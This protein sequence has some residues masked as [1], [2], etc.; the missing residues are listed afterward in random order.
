MSKN[1]QYKQQQAAAA[2]ETESQVAEAQAAETEVATEAVTETPVE[3]VVEETNDVEVTTEDTS[4][5]DTPTEEQPVVDQVAEEALFDQPV[6]TADAF[7]AEAQPIVEAE[8][9]YPTSFEQTP[10]EG[11]YPIN[12][13]TGEPDVPFDAVS[14]SVAAPFIADQEP[15][16]SVTAQFLKADLEQYEERMKLSRYTPPAEGAV[17]QVRLFRMQQRVFNNTTDDEFDECLTV[18]LDW[19]WQH[20]DGIASEAGI[21]RFMA[22][23]TAS[24]NEAEAFVRFNSLLMMI[25]DPRSRRPDILS[26]INA[27]YF[28]QYGLTGN[29]R[30]RLLAFLGQ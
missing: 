25:A 28:L 7:V 20:A 5:E 17:Q 15:E 13:L 4:V 19:Y 9:E 26:K 3:S 1:R 24:K 8:P 21:N 10:A 6:E 16:L 22:E 14:E 27:N 11:D 23:W 2:A 30:E 12:P 18:L 29:G